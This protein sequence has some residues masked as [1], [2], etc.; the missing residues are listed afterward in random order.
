[1]ADPLPLE[2]GP[3]GTGTVGAAPNII[4]SLDDS[5]SMGVAGMADLR[6]AVKTA[7][8]AAAVPDDRVRIAYQ[9]FASCN[10]LTPWQ[11]PSNGA[12]DRSLRL[13]SLN[14]TVRQQMF[15][16]LDS[17]TASSNT[18][19]HMLFREAGRFMR[20]TGAEGPYAARP[21]VSEQP[22]LSCRKSFHIFMTDG[23]WN[24]EVLSRATG[25][26]VGNADGV[27]RTLPDG[28]IYD[29]YGSTDAMARVYRDGYQPRP[30]APHPYAAWFPGYGG[31]F[32]NSLADFAFDQWASDLQPGIDNKVPP[33]IREPGEA[34][35]GTDQKPFRLP[36][37]W[38]PKNDP[39]TW[40]HLVTYTIGFNA[41]ARLPGT[42]A[43]NRPWWA[44]DAWSGDLGALIRG[45]VGWCNPMTPA[46]QRG[47]G[48]TP[49]NPCSTDVA[50]AR[51]QELWHIALNGRGR[52]IPATSAGE[53][54]AAFSEIVN[55][56]KVDSTQ[57][58]V[59][60]SSNTQTLGA[61]SQLFFAGFES[62]QWNG[63]LQAYPVNAAGE[64]GKTM[65]WDAAQKLDMSAPAQRLIWTHNG[66]KGVMLD[67]ATISAAQQDQLKGG[68]AGRVPDGQS[69]LAYLRGDRSQEVQ[70]RGALRNRKSVLGD[71]VHSTPW[72]VGAPEL[73][74]RDESYRE[75]VKSQAQR[76][77]MVYVGANDGMVH[78][79]STTDGAEKL[80][81]LPLGAWPGL[82]DLS[83]PA[84]QHRYSVDGSLMA[85]EVWDGQAWKTLLLGTL[86]LGGKGYFLLDVSAPESFVSQDPA[87]KVLL[88]RSDGQDPDIGQM[89]S[90]PASDPATPGRPS[91]ITQLNNGRWAVVLGNGV[92]SVSEKAV[93]L[94]QYLDGGREL[95]KLGASALPK[96]GNGLST[97]QLIDFNGDGKA[98]VAY[99]GDLLGQLWKFD[100]SQADASQW[101]VAMAGRPLFVA[102]DANGLRQ[103]LL[104]APNWMPHPYGGVML[105]FGSGRQLTVADRSVL[106]PQSLYAVWDDGKVS[107]DA[108]RA[109]LGDTTPVPADWRRRQ[110]S[111]LVQQSRTETRTVNGEV[112]YRSTRNP[113][114][115]RGAN[116][117]RGWFMDLAELQERVNT[118]GQVLGRMWLVRSQ[119]PARSDGSAAQ[120]ETCESSLSNAV[121]H[122][123]LLDMFSGAPAAWPAF[124]TDGGGFTGTELADISGWRSGAQARMWQRSGASEVVS[125][126][127]GA[128]MRLRVLGGPAG[129]IGWRQL[130]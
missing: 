3:A 91:Q 119:V 11:S 126:G 52:F 49:P 39:A 31:D 22:V 67:W 74:R 85:G 35:W 64:I 122:D 124:D 92:N 53:L 60:L 98:D 76:P 43:A 19:S 127:R 120:V 25:S 48:P 59:A 58:D 81:Y 37:Y 71:I 130:Q 57:L 17:L 70:N 101:K 30:D 82:R 87:Q 114:A 73:W 6:N 41:A 65:A 93:L 13:R 47:D 72:Y 5:G 97:P 2:T 108:S 50:Q 104:A 78:G 115:Y 36:E 45:E 32:Y 103:P 44:G 83:D 7:F 129:R 75:Y 40:Q 46:S 61:D 8:S 123:Y 105:A 106:G 4:L 118:D 62:R 89:V 26:E 27:R 80:A 128:P 38:N 88:D 21:G 23:E 29:P 95:I 90:G 125:V 109:V 68:A 42:G 55:Q 84:Y 15:A 111:A 96:Q 121:S 1:M 63:Y 56:I 86:G 34:N 28:K 69:R 100:L 54:Q 99:A 110:P 113:V 16:W 33:T 102:T 112:F 18:P 116:P 51:R 79:F 9:S 117:V 107:F 24:M 14:A 20:T 94:I 77:G 10:S 66:Q 12:C